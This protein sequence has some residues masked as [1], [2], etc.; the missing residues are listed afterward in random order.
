MHKRVV[1]HVFQ[2]AP[3]CPF[4]VPSPTSSVPAHPCHMAPSDV[5]RCLSERPCSS[6]SK[7]NQFLLQWSTMRPLQPPPHTHCHPSCRRSPRQHPAVLHRWA[8]PP[9]RNE[10]GTCVR[11]G[12]PWIPH[13]YVLWM[14]SSGRWRGWRCRIYSGGLHARVATRQTWA[15]PHSSPSNWRSLRWLV[16]SLKCH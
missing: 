11:T 13:M 1:H 4:A 12:A 16:V 8:Y 14:H 7:H 2:S 3:I 15:V 9:P 5:Y 6:P 10:L